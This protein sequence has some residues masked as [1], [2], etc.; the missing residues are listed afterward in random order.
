MC[1]KQDS[2]RVRIG[3]FRVLSSG[4]C[5]EVNRDSKRHTDHILWNHNQVHW[6]DLIEYSGHSVK[7]HNVC[8]LRVELLWPKNKEKE[9]S[10]LILIIPKTKPSQEQVKPPEK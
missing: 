10:R 6:R 7:P 4:R 3:L 5:F 9:Y 2:V 1:L 8:T